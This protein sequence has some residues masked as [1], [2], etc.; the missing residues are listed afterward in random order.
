M[1][2]RAPMARPLTA[3][4]AADLARAYSMPPRADRYAAHVLESLRAVLWP[5]DDPDEQWS[6]DTIAAVADILV[7]NGYGPVTCPH[8]ARVGEYP[9]DTL[10]CDLGADHAGPHHDQARDLTW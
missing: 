2:P 4:E 8:S 3:D 5:P 9:Q 1:S 10:T 6:P 7:A